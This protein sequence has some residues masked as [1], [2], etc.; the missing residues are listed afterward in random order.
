ME[1]K[2]MKLTHIVNGLAVSAQLIAEDFK[3][4][5]AQGYGAVINN[6]PDGE[7][8][9]YLNAFDAQA[10]A[11][12]HGLEYIH[13]PVTPAELTA[14]AVKR[15]KSALSSLPGP[16]VAHCGTGK[17]STAMWALSQAGEFGVDDILEQCAV[18]GHD[19]SPLRPR[20]AIKLDAA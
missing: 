6:R 10:L 18:A 20:L 17:R 14:D 7:K 3:T 13:I 19:L 12:S 8:G 5:A 16:V 1:S 11:H 4:I 15:F 9:D 2:A